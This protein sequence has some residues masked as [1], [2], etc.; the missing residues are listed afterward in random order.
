[1][2]VHSQEKVVKNTV[3]YTAA[4]I[5][6]KAISFVYFWVLS[7]HLAPSALGAYLGMLSFASL[8]SIGMDLGLTPLL[9][10]QAAKQEDEAGLLLR[11]TYAIKVP[12][13]IA[14]TALLWLVMLTLS[15]LHVVTLTGTEWLLLGGASVIIALDAFTSGAYAILRAQQNVMVES[16]AIVLF[17]LTVL[18]TGCAS[19]FL[20]GNILLIMASLMTGSMVNTVYTLSRVRRLL[21]TSI[22]PQADMPCI[23]TILGMLPSFATA[24]I[25]TKV[26][27]QADVVL[28]RSLTDTH[29]VGLYSIPAKITTALQSLIPGAF[30]AAVYPTLSNYAHTDR[31]RL[32][33]LFRYTFGILFLL[34]L[35]V[36]AFLAILT[37][38]L[39][40][41]VWPQ[42]R[43]VAPAMAAMLAVVPF[44]FLPYAT[45]AL[46][47]AVGKERQTSRNRIIM[48]LV[49]VAINI[50]LI[51][52]FRERGAAAAFVTANVVLASLDI[53]AAHRI[54]SLRHPD[55]RRLVFG[56]VFSLIPSAGGLFLYVAWNNFIDISR[57]MRSFW[58]F[59]V[60]PLIAASLLYVVLLVVTKT[61]RTEDVLRLKNMLM[62]QPEVV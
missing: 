36:G 28:L 59:G 18:V 30:S 7:S 17:Q 25:F 10:R 19:V 40:A 62:R 54:V 49:N 20:T 4:T 15:S 53:V 21:G 13:V 39:L 14:T 22:T 50:A 1:M 27:Q 41:A 57:G 16:R 43:A 9:T 37:P 29:T 46:L 5:A 35:P 42:Y 38:V 8:A 33:N 31:A 2:S 60:A 12:L 48:T 32:E 3:M 58:Y 55:V 24:G 52:F 51:P 61:V 26:Y 56:A 45:G 11:A 34:S 23:R 47:N 6:Q 44:L